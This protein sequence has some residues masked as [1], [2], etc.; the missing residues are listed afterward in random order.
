MVAVAKEEKESS[1][2]GLGYLKMYPFFPGPLGVSAAFATAI[3]EASAVILTTRC[4]LLL[5]SHFSSFI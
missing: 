3:L 4:E 5:G 1:F 2:V